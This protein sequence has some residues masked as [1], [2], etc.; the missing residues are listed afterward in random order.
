MKMVLNNKI[1][2]TPH[3]FLSKWW[4]AYTHIDGEIT[5]HISPYQQKVIRPWLKAFPKEMA[6]HA[7]SIN[8][9]MLG[10]GLCFILGNWELGEHVGHQIDR[11]HW[12]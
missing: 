4:D 12:D 10:F 3:P 5:E 11:S 1:R 2:K 7:K 6:T 9:W 8:V